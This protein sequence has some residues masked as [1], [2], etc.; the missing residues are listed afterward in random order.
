[1]QF[2]IGIEYALRFLLYDR[3]RYHQQDCC[4]AASLASDPAPA[5]RSFIVLPLVVRTVPLGLF[6][7][8]RT[9]LAPEGA[10][11]DEAALIN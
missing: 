8:D 9:T 2:S 4:P 5:P 7:A 6:Y 11:P 3:R 10:S 1:M